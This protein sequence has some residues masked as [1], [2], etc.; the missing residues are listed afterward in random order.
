MATLPLYILLCSAERERVQMAAM[1]ASIA[2]V[3]ERPVHVFVS[4]GAIEVFAKDRKGAARYAEQAPFSQTL[5]K[6]QVPDPIDLFGQGKMLGEI[7]MHAC[8]MVMDVLGW[9][10]DALTDGLFDGQMGLTKFL[11]DAETGQLMTL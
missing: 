8:S 11:S 5:G 1:V 3:S 6:K 2:A 10:D 9:D 4:M 7:G